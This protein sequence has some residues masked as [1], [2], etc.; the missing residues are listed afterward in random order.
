MYVSEI[1]RAQVEIGYW[2]LWIPA[3]T[4][5]WM[6]L[7]PSLAMLEKCKRRKQLRTVI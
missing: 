1:F 5:S 6:L 4:K 3:T 2:T 7:C